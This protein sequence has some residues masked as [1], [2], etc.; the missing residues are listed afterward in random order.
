[1]ARHRTR[2]DRRYQTWRQSRRAHRIEHFVDYG[3]RQCNRDCENALGRFRKA[4]AF[5][6][7]CRARHKGAPKLAGSLHKS[8]G[9]YRTT[10]VRRI[11]NKRLAHA[12]QD[13]VGAADPDGCELP[14]GPIIGRRRRTRTW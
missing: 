10:V 2:G 11:W 4:K 5:Q 9:S 12:W 8:F 7:R 6:C 3:A 1:M 13:A 14:S